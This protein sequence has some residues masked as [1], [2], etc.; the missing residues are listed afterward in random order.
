MKKTIFTT[1]LAAVLLCSASLA[2]AKNGDPAPK[3][4]VL[5]RGGA[6]NTKA[7]Y[8]KED[9]ASDGTLQQVSVLCG[10]DTAAGLVATDT[11]RTWGAYMESNVTTAVN[12]G[13]K[14]I[15]DAQKG[16]PNHCV[17]NNLTLSQIK[18][19]WH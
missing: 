16:N 17:I 11:T 5:V 9:Q 12:L 18:G 2:V 6:A 10:N 1:A 19:I 14:V 13:G 7:N 8:D 4:W 15:I 3:G